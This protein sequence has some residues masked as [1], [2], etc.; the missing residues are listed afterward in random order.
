MSQSD[1]CP[2]CLKTYLA[3][4]SCGRCEYDLSKEGRKCTCGYGVLE[5]TESRFC[6]MRTWHHIHQTCEHCG[7]EG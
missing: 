2:K 1:T 3:C 6:C 5:K 7:Q 4:R